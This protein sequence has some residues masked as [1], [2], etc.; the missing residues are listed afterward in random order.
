MFCPKCGAE[1]ADD[2]KVCPNCGLDFSEIKTT[3]I[4]KAGEVQAVKEPVKEKE[5]VDNK[6][7]KTLSPFSVLF[8]GL[9]VVVLVMCFIASNNISSGG[10]EIMQIQSVG[11]K[12]LEEAYY[13]ELG[14]IYAG[15]TMLAR[16]FGIFAASVLTWMGLKV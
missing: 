12:T 4:E 3:E 11:G 10:N 13:F 16:A 2:V 5:I 6:P 8:F 15:Y 9:A 1:V 7:K 14:S